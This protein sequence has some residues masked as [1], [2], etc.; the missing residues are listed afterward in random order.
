[1]KKFGVVS[2]ILVCCILAGCEA[3]G[4]E[5]GNTSKKFSHKVTV[6]DTDGQFYYLSNEVLDDK[7]LDLW[8]HADRLS[9]EEWE[10]R[11]KGGDD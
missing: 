11:Y 5:G 9:D 8:W 7:D 10:E 3:K 1:M 4:K 6:R 2:L